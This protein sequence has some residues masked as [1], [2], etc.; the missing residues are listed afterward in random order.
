MLRAFIVMHVN[1]P[2]TSV[3]IYHFHLIHSDIL[4]PST[5]PN[6]YRAR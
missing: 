5:I 2:N 4:G 1:C 3:Y 6:I